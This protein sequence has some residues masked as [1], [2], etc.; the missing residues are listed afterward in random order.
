MMLREKQTHKDTQRVP[1]LTRNVLNRETQTQ[2]KEL[3][4]LRGWG[5]R[6]GRGMMDARMMDGW[7]DGRMAGWKDDRW[8]DGW[9]IDVWI[10]MNGQM[11]GWMERWIDGWMGSWM[12]GWMLVG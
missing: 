1:P 6:V 4:G 5:R 8:L 3:C 2:K 11:N 9:M 12:D 10:M 7:V